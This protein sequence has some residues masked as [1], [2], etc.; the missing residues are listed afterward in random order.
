METAAYPAIAI[1]GSAIGFIATV[2]GWYRFFK[3]GAASRSVFGSLS[4][5]G[6]VIGSASALVALGLYGYIALLRSK[7]DE[8]TYYGLS[9]LGIVL[10]FFAVLFAC[11]GA[12]G[13]SPLR[14]YALGSAVG[15]FAFWWVAQPFP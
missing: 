12:V 3:A 15:T 4:F 6:F 5:A 11:A 13:K 7:V 14:W 8:S 1:A 2:F 9:R 10:S